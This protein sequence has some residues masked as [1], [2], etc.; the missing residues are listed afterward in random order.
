MN[1]MNRIRQS[2]DGKYWLIDGDTHITKWVEECRRLDHDRGIDRLLK[3]IPRGGVVVDA[4]A[5]IGDHTVAYAEK[6]GPE[7]LV[8][9][10]EPNMAPFVCM[11]MN[12]RKYS[13]V[14]PFNFG[15]GW[16]LE[17]RSFVVDY[18]NLGASSV[19]DIKTREQ[20]LV[21]QLDEHARLIRE[22][23]R[24]DFFKL[25]VEGME[26]DAIQGASNLIAK[27]KPVIFFEVNKGVL[28]RIGLDM[29]EV[30]NYVRSLG[31]TIQNF[32]PGKP[33]DF[34]GP[35]FDVLCFPI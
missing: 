19:D 35:Q 21:E 18:N 28:N 12:M 6:V 8:M 32:D 7:G 20:I 5:S 14:R 26:Y 10:F 4:G 11:A 9:A 25:D 13:Q 24:F 1:L 29:D 22:R 2:I 31:Y 27:Y 30:F 3:Y 15:L 23:D 34:S 16:R 33:Q 17:R